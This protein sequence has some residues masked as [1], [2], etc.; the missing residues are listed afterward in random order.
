MTSPREASCLEGRCCQLKSNC[1]V[2]YSAIGPD[3]CV[4]VWLLVFIV[5]TLPEILCSLA[6]AAGTRI[7]TKDLP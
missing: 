5:K 4:F 2:L 1:E 7:R 6:I 3:L